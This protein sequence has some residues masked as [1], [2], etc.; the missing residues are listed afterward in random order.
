MNTLQG[1]L[2]SIVQ[3][4]EQQEGLQRQLVQLDSS[5]A[6]LAATIPAAS[7]AAASSLGHSAGLECTLRPLAGSSSGSSA[8][9]VEVQLRNRSSAPLEGSWSLLLC[10]SCAG[11]DGWNGNGSVMWAATLG[12]LAA[13]AAWS[14]QCQLQLSIV[15]SAA[16]QLRVLLCRHGSGSTASSMLLLLHA[17]Q[18]D[19]LHSLQ[20][21][22]GSKAACSTQQQAAAEGAA[23]SSSA[24]GVQARMLLQLPTAVHGL[25]PAASSLLNVLRRQGLSNQARKQLAEQSQQAQPPHP[26]FSLLQP[27]ATAHGRVGGD[28]GS[29]SITDS[30]MRALRAQLLPTVP[31]TVGQQQQVVLATVAA[32]TAALLASHQA[33]CRRT[34]RLQAGAAA[35]VQ[36]QQQQRQLPWPRVIGRDGMLLPATA[37]GPL[38]PPGSAAAAAVDEAALEQALVQLRQL[39]EA[40]MAVRCT[41]ADGA[42]PTPPADR[43]R[44]AE[45][46]RAQV[47]RQALAA[48]HTLA[49]VPVLLHGPF[50]AIV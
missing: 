48:R 36:E 7:S 25:P 17:V 43:Q 23:P 26:A 42:E 28:S 8:L 47:Q 46:H 50:F 22:G 13:G 2:G 6:G 29:S 10:H 33:L 18:L 24:P 41:A 3:L 35:A 30:A 34:L 40:A 14:R 20:L 37:A 44:Q 39:R 9:A 1:L 19:A 21:E 4:S 16:G 12:G 49:T 27:A 31:P 11:R 38:L 45:A 32:D 15:R 5:I